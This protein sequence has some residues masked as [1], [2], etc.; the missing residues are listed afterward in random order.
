M[1]ERMLSSD[2]LPLPQAYGRC[3]CDCHS[4]PGVKH[5]APCCYPHDD[6]RFLNGV[7]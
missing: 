1:A 4:F 7:T 3:H 2:E 5:V 6:D